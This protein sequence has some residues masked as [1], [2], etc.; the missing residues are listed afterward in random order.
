MSL[1]STLMLGSRFSKTVPPSCC[2]ITSI[3]CDLCCTATAS[4]EVF[5]SCCVRFQKEL[6]LF[7]GLYFSPFVCMAF[8]CAIL[9]T[10]CLPH[11]LAGLL[12][13]CHDKKKFFDLWTKTQ[14]NKMSKC[15]LNTC[16]M[17]KFSKQK[18]FS[19]C[20]LLF[21]LFGQKKTMNSESSQ[22]GFME[23]HIQKKVWPLLPGTQSVCHGIVHIQI[24]L[25]MICVV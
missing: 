7:V 21:K 10:M 13:L 3:F 5:L 2:C 12:A 23:I 6:P 1:F 16:W 4:R 8:F 22:S 24:S 20:I 25:G 14:Q 15:I 11:S 17:E 19:R 9:K 18:G